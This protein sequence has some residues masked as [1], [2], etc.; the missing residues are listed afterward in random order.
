MDR[1]DVV[2]TGMGAIAPNGTGLENYWEGISEGRSGAKYLE[3]FDTEDYPVDFAATVDDFDS[4]EYFSRREKNRMDT[5]VQMGIVAAEEAIERAGY[6]RE[7]PEYDPLRT[8]VIIGSGIGGIHTIEKQHEVFLDRGPR[9]ISPYLIPKLIINMVSGQ[10]AIRNN[11][12]GPNK[13]VVT[14]CATSAHAIGDAARLIQYGEADV[15][16]AGGAEYGTSRLGFGGF[17]AIK[18]LSTRNDD[19]QGASRPFDAERDGFVMGEGSGAMVLESREHAE[20]RGAEIHAELAGYGQNSDAHHMTAPREDGEGAARCMRLAVDDAD[21]EYSKVDYINAHGTSTPQG[22]V[23]ETK[24]IKKVFED[25]AWELKISSTKSTTGHLLGAAGAI[26]AIATVLSL[27]NDL[28]PP[29]INYENP[30]PDCDLDY[31]PN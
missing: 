13:S 29:T 23:A 18:A 19:P 24:A 28:L 14:A 3:R 15:M 9:R 21:L 8:G 25:H 12:E 17:C 26:E 10:V 4:D 20:Q 1:R 30:D 5:F 7:D 6:N 11:C 27:E 22:D 31:V 16:I 2:V